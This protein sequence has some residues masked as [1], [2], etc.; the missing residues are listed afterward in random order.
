MWTSRR[1]PLRKKRVFINVT[2]DGKAIPDLNEVKL[3]PKAGAMLD[4]LA[5]IPHVYPT[6]GSKLDADR[7]VVLVVP[8]WQITEG[9]RRLFSRSVWM[10]ARA[11]SVAAQ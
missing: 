1:P 2:L 3:F 10:T 9:L 11:S 6:V 5:P 7:F 8:N 4:I